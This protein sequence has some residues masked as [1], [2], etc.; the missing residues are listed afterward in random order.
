MNQ[1]RLLTLTDGRS[2]E[3]ID[4][5][6][7]SARAL[8]ML[9]GTPGVAEVWWTWLSRA[10]ELGVRAIAVTR[11]GYYV[12]HRRPVG[13]VLDLNNDW[14]Q[15]LHQCAVEEFVTLGWSGGGPYSLAS[16]FIT[17][18]RGA[19]L[20]AGVASLSEMGLDFGIG[21]DNPIEADLAAAESV[22]NAI[23]QL[24]GVAED[25]GSF[26]TSFFGEYVATRPNYAE[27]AEQ[28]K[29]AQPHLSKFAT[30]AL[31][32]PLGLAEDSHT[33]CKDW[34]FK[35][36]DVTAAVDIWQGEIDKAVPVGHG[37]WLA[38]QMPN[39][40][41]HE[42]PHQGHSTIMVEAREPILQSAIAKLNA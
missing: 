21:G 40:A 24:D 22:E 29:E 35:V 26:V 11:P 5:G 16:T 25:M 19:E 18:N 39:S 23:K 3:I 20:V 41:L 32:V 2:L 33:I 27:F 13:T 8:I 36:A 6:I 12:S 31:A 38:A 28:Y 4:N 17:G 37:R 34:G 42:L 10:A 15:V 7:N 1:T 9:H 14:M 30:D